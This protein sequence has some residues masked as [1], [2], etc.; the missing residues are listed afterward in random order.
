[1][2]AP[3]PI[4]PSRNRAR[5]LV[6]NQCRPLYLDR[7]RNSLG[8]LRPIRRR[9]LKTDGFLLSR[10]TTLPHGRSS[11]CWPRG[12]PSGTNNRVVRL[13]RRPAIAQGL[14]RIRIR[15]L[16]RSRGNS[17]LHR[18]R[19]DRKLLE[20]PRRVAGNSRLRI[21]VF[22]A[23]QR[24]LRSLR[25]LR[26]RYTGSLLSVRTRC[27]RPGEVGDPTLGRCFKIPGPSLGC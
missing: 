17:L 23:G 27:Y 22:R 12:K 1:M 7:L 25:R 10:Y 11:R 4:G 24:R 13:G 2:T 5:Y 21:P 20:R 8:D 9:L 18:E 19:R 15:V 14:F 16:I 3:R 26:G 6:W